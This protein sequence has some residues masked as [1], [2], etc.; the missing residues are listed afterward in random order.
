[1]KTKN[2]LFALITL[3][4]MSG[5][6]EVFAITHGSMKGTGLPL[7]DQY[8]KDPLPENPIAGFFI[9][10]KMVTLGN[11]TYAW[12]N[13][14]GGVLGDAGWA[15]QLRYWSSANN[16]TENNLVERVGD[17]QSYGFGG[18]LP[19]NP[20]EIS[21]FQAS[22]GFKESARFTYDATLKNSA[23]AGD[24]TAPVLTA[25]A[26]DKQDNSVVL[27]LDGQDANDVFYYITD[28]EG[29]ETIA[30]TNNFPLTGLTSGTNYSYTVTAI[31]FNGNESAP[32]TVNFQTTGTP[33]PFDVTENLA[34]N[35][36]SV[37]SSGTAAAGNDGNDDSRWE[38]A[39]TDTEWWYVNLGKE[40]VV[41]DIKIM[42]EGAFSKQYK[43]QVALTLPADPAG[44]EGWTTVYTQTNKTGGTKPDWDDLAFTA[45]PAKFVKFQAIER[46]IP[47]GNSFWEFQVYGTGY[48]DP[49]AGDE[50]AAVTVSPTGQT[51]YVGDEFQFTAYPLNGASLPVEDAT[52]TWSVEPA[53]TASISNGLFVAQATGVYTVT[54]TATAGDITKS[55]T[56]TITVEA[57]R[58]P[59]TLT[60]TLPNSI[61][62]AKEK[63]TFTSVVTDQYGKVMNN[64]EVTYTT[65]SGVIDE[66]AKTITFT[67]KEGG[68]VTL[69]AA[70][71]GTDLQGTINLTVVTNNKLK[72]ANMTATATTELTNAETGAVTQ[73]ASLAIDGNGDTRWVSITG[74][75]A[76]VG[77]QSITVDLG[78]LHKLSMVEIEWEGAYAKDYD[79]EVSATEDGAYTPIAEYRNLAPYTRIHRTLANPDVEVQ[80]IRV[81]G[82]TAATGYGYSIW[83]ITAYEAGLPNIVT[84]NEGIAQGISFKLDSRTGNKLRIQGDVVNANNKIGDA[85]VKISIDGTYIGEEFKPSIGADGVSRYYITVPGNQ[86]PGYEE[87]QYLELNLGYII[88]PIGDWSG[89]VVENAY[90]TSGDHTGLPIIHEVGTGVDLDVIVEEPPFVCEKT[91]LLDGKTLSAGEVFYATGEGWASSTNYTFAVENNA[92]NIHLGDATWFQWQAQ[93]RAILDNPVD[94]IAGESYS[95]Q[96]NVSTTANIPLYVKF[97]DNND[98]AFL[99]IPLQTVAAPGKV[100]QRL[101]IPCP[102]DLTQ[103]TQIL[104]DFGGNAANTDLTISDFVICGEP[105]DVGIKAVN[106]K[107]ISIYPTLVQDIL[108]INGIQSEAVKVLDIAGKTVISQV[109]NGD[110][111]VSHLNAGIYILQVKGA[112]AKFIKQ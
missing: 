24:A 19:N 11:K 28:G 7:Y 103:I 96:F 1:M 83:E 58:A 27:Q 29:Y 66:A 44:D 95:L 92:L 35:K 2:L 107:A 75:P 5:L 47:Y 102:G 106:A 26:T 74:D 16:V 45:T 98:N 73:P 4:L 33:P 110:L 99:D 8:N 89:Y 86:V 30:F 49:A 51:T 68:S 23:V 38:S 65:T 34:L 100:L 50:L 62:V 72:K 94:L 80:F 91:N 69:T 9:D 60:F 32:Q 108:H 55:G 70:V 81:H 93:F 43:I 13:I 3:M 10:Y 84:T 12:T 15:S 78:G 14:T 85:F 25:T 48:Y 6:N 21:F 20:L 79:I 76:T 61:Y 104:F 97:F 18:A 111:D 112:T 101:N 57:A 53:A 36:I 77:E 40:Y 63:A 105:A 17:T 54:A 41:N 59:A 31:D 52:V 56:A 82:I 87:G 71:T 88:L 64:A 37:A 90:I 39:H 22:D 42:W 46:A 67:E 109:S